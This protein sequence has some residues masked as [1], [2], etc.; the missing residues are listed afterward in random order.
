MD[1]QI[2]SSLLNTDSMKNILNDV[3]INSINLNFDDIPINSENHLANRNK[4]KAKELIQR[5]LKE[6]LEQRIFNSEKTTRN[7]LVTIKN[8]KDLA[9]S[10]TK[11]TLKISKQIEEKLKR[12]KEKQSK[13]KPIK[14]PNTKNKK[15]FSPHKLISNKT[16]SNFYRSKTPSHYGKNGN[17]TIHSKTPLAKLKKDLSKS[18]S[19]VALI[20]GKNLLKNNGTNSK[21]NTRRKSLGRKTKSSLNFKNFNNTNDYS[22]DDLH[23]VSVTSIKTNKTNNISI[24]TVTNSKLNHYKNLNKAAKKKVGLRQN[25]DLSKD[26]KMSSN[27]KNLNVTNNNINININTSSEKNIIINLGKKK[28]IASKQSNLI[29]NNNNLDNSAEKNMKRKKTPFNKRTITETNL[30]IKKGEKTVEDE[31]DD[32]LTME[33]KL[34][35]ENI[36]NDNDPLLILPMN[37]LDFVPK[38]ILRKYSVRNDMRESRRYKLNNFNIL[39]NLD[40]SKF[41]INIF[42]FLDIYTLINIKNVSKIFRKSVLAFIIK[43]LKEEKEKVLNIKESLNITTIP[44][45]EDFENLVL[46]KGS[47]KAMQLLNE[48]LLNHLFKDTKFPSN[49][50]ILIYRIYFQMINHPYSLIA[51]KDI[52]TFWEKCKSYFTSEQNGKTGDILLTMINQKKI[53]FGKNNEF[54]IYML[55]KNNYKKILPNYFSNICGTTGLFVFVIKDILEFMGITPKIKKK[56]NAFWTYSDIADSIDEK[57]NYL[58]KL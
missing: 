31:I 51:K 53:D 12:D 18:K 21:L 35:K 52:F 44:E 49:D 13:T 6:S 14:V 9:I 58:N 16:S 24:N 33:G 2:K 19:N 56:E 30:N 42:K 32:I 55:A 38:N 40:Q 45:R 15:G 36:L 39:E 22:L 41:E 8:T 34:Q 23:T 43:I 48:S 17:S 4:E 54:Q 27:T 50:I 28:N 29:S 3:Q 26:S 25:L 20:K 57:I 5:L 1:N 7:Q 46:N 10:I 11:V 37:D 47:K